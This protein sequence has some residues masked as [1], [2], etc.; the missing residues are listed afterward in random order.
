MVPSNIIPAFILLF[1]IFFFS[2]KMSKLMAV[3]WLMNTRKIPTPKATK[4]LFLSFTLYREAEMFE[5]G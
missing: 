4:V 1:L 3:M 2:A 5:F